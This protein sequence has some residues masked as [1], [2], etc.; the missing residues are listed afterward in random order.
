MEALIQAHGVLRAIVEKGL[1]YHQCGLFHDQLVE[2]T[3]FDSKNIAPR[4]APSYGKALPPF[5]PDLDWKLGCAHAGTHVDVY[6][7]HQR[8]IDSEARLIILDAIELLKAYA[9]TLLSETEAD[10][11][12]KRLHQLGFLIAHL[13]IQMS[14]RRG[15]GMEPILISEHNDIVS[16]LF[17]I[18]KTIDEK[19][20]QA[21]ELARKNQGD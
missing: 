10:S 2:I 20:A 13:D 14:T 11:I 18:A 9:P 16:E 4:G 7:G 8:A 5:C 3:L 17:A 19:V 1:P 15:E 21:I 6:Q 12:S